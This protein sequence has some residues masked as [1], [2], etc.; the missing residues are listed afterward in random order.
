MIHDADAPAIAVADLSAT[1]DGHPAIVEVSFEVA[2]GERLAIVGPNG[3]GKSTLLRALAGLHPPSSGSVR[4]HGHAPQGHI[5]IAY[6]PQQSTVD[7]RFPVTVADVV[8]MGRIGRVGPLSRLRAD[9]REIVRRALAEVE[10]DGFA[11]RRIEALSGGER[12]RM[13]VARALAQ[14]SEIVLMDEPF[15]GLDVHSREEVINVLDGL[16]SHDVTLLVAL[17]DLG[18]ASAH[19]D[20]I[21]LLKGRALGFG[22]PNDI[23][24][25]AALQR[26]YGSCLRMVRGE[27]GV[28]VVHD[29]ACSGGRSERPGG[30]S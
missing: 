12:Q 27:D 16:R 14:E 9:D 25:E 2:A 7:W 29:T 19:F 5:C 28:L 8:S 3:A 22:S 6:V 10:L 13:F 1:Y 11:E 15:A 21:L 30:T 20:K 26:A 17:H 18:L 24:T 23:L 4:V